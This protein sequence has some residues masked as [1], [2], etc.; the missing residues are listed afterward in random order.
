MEGKIP[1]QMLLMMTFLGVRMLVVLTIASASR[2]EVNQSN[3]ATWKH[4]IV[5][6]QLD[7]I[8]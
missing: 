3:V 8:N 7:G 1:D 6:N 2:H 5:E 4:V